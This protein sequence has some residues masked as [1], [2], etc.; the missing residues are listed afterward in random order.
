MCLRPEGEGR[1][2][3]DPD[4]RRLHIWLTLA[5]RYHKTGNRAYTHIPSLSALVLGAA[6]VLGGSVG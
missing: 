3:G 6:L 4:D 5:C 2:I 1:A